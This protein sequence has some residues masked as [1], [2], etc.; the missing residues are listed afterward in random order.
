MDTPLNA[1]LTR[2]SQSCHFNK[3]PAALT[4]LAVA[5]VGI[6]F[7]FTSR[8]AT[9]F[10]SIEP[11]QGAK[12]AGATVGNDDTASGGQFV[13]FGGGA[14]SET[15]KPGPTNTGPTNSS[16]LAPSGS[17][18]I[19]QDGAVVENVAVNGIVRIQANNVTIRNFR[20]NGGGA[21]YGIQATYGYSGGIIED[22]EVYNVNSAGIYGGGFTARRLNVHESGGD[23]VKPTSNVVF[24]TSWLHNLGTNDGAHADGFQSV[25]GSNYT[26]RGNNCDMP[27]TDPPPYKSNACFIIQTNN[28]PIDN[29]LI[30][31]N[32]LNGGNFTVY[33]TDKGN[34]HGAPTNARI[35]NNR[36]GRDYRYGLLRTDG[37]PVISGNVWDDTGGLA[38]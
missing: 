26:F 1:K 9:P 23:A 27:V 15:A 16:E 17:I 35:L 36:F 8:A 22:G 11:E 37:N 4:I 20:I 3:L 24:E 28:S 5:S 21:S 32:W 30:E 10:A 19:T 7:T 38:P 34:G 6:A 31:N 14:V 12:T 25:G 33:V 2:L 29:V 18:T 13:Q